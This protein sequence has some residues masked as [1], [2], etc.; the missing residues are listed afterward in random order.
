MHNTAEYYLK[1]KYGEAVKNEL[2]TG[3]ANQ[4]D[5]LILASLYVQ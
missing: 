1:L 2:A 3:K 4:K 5:R